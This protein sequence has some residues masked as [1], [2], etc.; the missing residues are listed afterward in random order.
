MTVL[1][2]KNHCQILKQHEDSRQLRMDFLTKNI[3]DKLCSSDTPIKRQDTA[4]IISSESYEKVHKIFMRTVWITRK[5]PFNIGP[6]FSPLD[7]VYEW[8]LGWE[9]PLEGCLF[10]SI[11]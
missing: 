10:H 11:S 9:V 8:K 7:D 1:E 3:T 5:L 4:M 2:Q 6:L